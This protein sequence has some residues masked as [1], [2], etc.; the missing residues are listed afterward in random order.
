M[1][2]SWQAE[3]QRLH[4][5]YRCLVWHQRAP[6]GRLCAGLQ[7]SGREASELSPVRWRL[8]RGCGRLKQASGQILMMNCVVASIGRVQT[9]WQVEPRSRCSTPRCSFGSV[10]RNDDS[11]LLSVCRKEIHGILVN[12]LA[13]KLWLMVAH[14]K[15]GTQS[16]CMV[17]TEREVQC[18]VFMDQVAGQEQALVQS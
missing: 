13:L 16:H 14:R 10:V 1:L 3:C 9:A 18:C 6:E 5:R 11:V 4:R 15:G 2:P 7:R 12:G 17:D 8:R